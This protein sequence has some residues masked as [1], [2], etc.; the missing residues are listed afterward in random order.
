MRQDLRLRRMATRMGETNR[1]SWTNSE[2]RE[3]VEA[4][5]WIG[6]TLQMMILTTMMMKRRRRRR[7][8]MAGMMD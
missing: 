1:T 2:R 7:K 4:E 3:P 5:L 8:M 6:R